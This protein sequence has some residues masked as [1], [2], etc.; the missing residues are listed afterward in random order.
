MIVATAFSQLRS[1]GFSPNCNKGKSQIMLVI[2][3]KRAADVKTY[4]FVN[5][6]AKLDV[7]E[8]VG[9]RSLVPMALDYKH[10]GSH[11]DANRSRA[12]EMV[13]RIAEAANASRELSRC[14]CRSQVEPPKHWLLA[15]SLCVTRLA[16]DAHT[17]SN[18]TS[19]QMSKLASAYN[20][21]ARNYV[22]K[23][24]VNIENRKTAEAALALCQ[25]LPFELHLQCVRPC[26]S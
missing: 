22:D 3:G 6:E 9:N 15:M 10:L 24:F 11:K 5:R 23:Q 14:T 26:F 13:H 2:I 7:I 8:D 21:S 1:V 17:E 16:Y 20:S 4:I 18:W 12:K 19:A 25:A